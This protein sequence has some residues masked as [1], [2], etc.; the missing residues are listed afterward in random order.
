M[1]RIITIER[2]YGCGAGAIAKAL[3]ARLGWALWDHEITCEIAKRLHCDVA[4]VES[5]EERPDPTL[6]RLMKVFM[7]GSYEDRFSG[8]GTELLDAEHLAELFEKV[9]TDVAQRGP[10]V[11]VGR[12]APWFLR[13]RA[14]AMHTFLFAGYE[15]KLRR[16]TAQGKSVAEAEDLIETVDRDRAAFVTKFVGKTWP[17]RDLY[18]LMVNSVIGDEGVIEIMLHEMQ[19]LNSRNGSRS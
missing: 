7:R 14:D 2:E 5:R 15:E 4:S 10:C 8:S 11:I 9:V 17:Q 13:Q 12:G 16:I 3:S 19:L 1:I 6:Y 18:H